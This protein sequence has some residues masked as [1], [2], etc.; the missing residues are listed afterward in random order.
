[1][2]HCNSHLNLL[3]NRKEIQPKEREACMVNNIDEI[4]TDCIWVILKKSLPDVF[5]VYGKSPGS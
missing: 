5:Q 1:M 4:E 3:N 2:K